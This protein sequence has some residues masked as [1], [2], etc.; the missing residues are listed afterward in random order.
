MN[1]RLARPS[2]S[3]ALAAGLLLAAA[4]A[5]AGADPAARP[6]IVSYD[7]TGARISGW[8]GWWHGYDGQITP[9]DADPTLAD[10][11][12]GSGTLNDGLVADSSYGNHLLR[13]ADAPVIT[14]HLAAPARIAGIAIL[15]GDYFNN[16]LV[17]SL[18]AWSV[19]IGGQTRHFAATGFGAPC[20][21]HL[22]DD[23][24]SLLGSGL[25]EVSTQTVVLSGFV[26]GNGHFAATEILLSAVPEPPAAALLALGLAALALRRGARGA[27]ARPRPAT[28]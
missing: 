12:G 5:M 23:R 13:T 15:G 8:S 28:S 10:Y 22:C 11:S 2:S 1:I 18:S 25:D 16:S 14:L 26:A 17:G 4:S 6:V 21:Q 7:I 3:A 27:S 9:R 19:T 20:E 24:V